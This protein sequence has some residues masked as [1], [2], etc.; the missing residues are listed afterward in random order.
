MPETGF[1]SIVMKRIN[2]N[3]FKIEGGNPQLELEQDEDETLVLPRV[4][5]SS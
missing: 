4:Q 5:R 2:I 3:G 1:Q